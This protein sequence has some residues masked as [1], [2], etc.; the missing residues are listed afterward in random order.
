MNVTNEKIKKF[1]K[2][3]CDD[4]RIASKLGRKL[5]EELSNRIKSLKENN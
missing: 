4:E 5:D 1:L 3:G 2:Q